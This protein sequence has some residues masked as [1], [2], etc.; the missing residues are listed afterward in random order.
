MNWHRLSIEE[1]YKF[2]GT[3][4]HGLSSIASEEKLLEVG[5]NVLEEGKKKNILN[6]FISQFKDLM[7]LILL[8]AAVISGIIG[9]ITDSIVILLIVL[10]NSLIGF[11]QEFKAEK[12][13]KALKN[14]AV[15]QAHVLREGKKI[16]LPATKLV[17]G[18]I[19]IMEA[20][21]AVPADLR[22]TKS[23]N[24]KIE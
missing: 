1:T 19:V 20:G 12:A 23:V 16:F 21:N 13:M 22:I 6:V 8:A 18:D 14:I 5:L 11:I 17:P 7:I 2:L 15:S 9:D 24:L 3:T 4:Q 10:V